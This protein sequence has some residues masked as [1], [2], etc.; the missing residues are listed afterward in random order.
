MRFYIIGECPACIGSGD[1]LALLSKKDNSL[2]YYCPAC[3]LAWRDMPSQVD[4]MNSLDDFAPN[5]VIAAGKDDLVSRGIND[6]D[7]T[8]LYKDINDIR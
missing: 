1:L 8:E 7:V 3:G 2:F 6:F 5:G 4:E